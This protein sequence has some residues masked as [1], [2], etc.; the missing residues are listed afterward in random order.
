MRRWLALSLLVAA[1]S[2]YPSPLARAAAPAAAAVIPEG[3]TV[4]E[5]RE[6][7]TSALT[8]Y[9]QGDAESAAKL[10]TRVR[11]VYPELA[12]YAE[13][14]LAKIAETNDPTHAVEHWRVIRERYA[15]S[16]WRGEAELAVARARAAE[17]DWATASRELT[18]ARADLKDAASRAA[19]LG[20]A[21]EAARRLG[22]VRQARTLATE[23][24][25]Q[26]P[27]SA[28]ASSERERAWAER[29][30]VALSVVDSAYEEISLLLG[31]G[32][33]SR[34][35]ELARSAED[36]FRG[37]DKDLPRLLLLEAT[38]LGRSGEEATAQ[39]LLGRIRSRYRRHPAAAQALFRL[40][41]FSWNHD[42]DA[43]ALRSFSAYEREYP[44][45]PQAA[46]ALYAIGRI[47]QEA[48]RYV[49]AANAFARL[50]RR[51]PRAAVADEA[52]FR[53]GWC[54][55]RA[56]QPAAAAR[57]FDALARRASG[58]RAAGLYW[59]ARTRRDDAGF[60]DVLQ[61]FPESYYG[62]LAEMRLGE[63]EASALRG[64][65]SSEPGIPSG[66][67]C[68]GAP[69]S[70]LARFNELKAVHLLPYARVELAAYQG[71]NDG[72]DAFLIV[73]WT[74]VEGYRQ[75]VARA[76]HSEGCGLDSPWVRACYPLAFWR[77]IEDR[78]VERSLDPFLVAGLIRQ[79][80]L[81]DAEARSSA[82]AVGLMQLLPATATRIAPRAGTEVHADR[83]GDPAANVN[84]GTAYLH[85]L[86]DRYQGNLPRALAAYNAGEAAV[87]K[88]SHRYAD[89]ED[90]EFVESIPYRET[91]GYVKRVLQ[92]RRI[93]HALYGTH[94]SAVPSP[95]AGARDGVKAG[96][97]CGDKDTSG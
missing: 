19:A 54:Q 26:Y 14:F 71:E 31:E 25:S 93:Y 7:F 79:E 33:V 72:C 53:V 62:A 35:L 69:S 15:D 27:R 13:R 92:N 43:D 90:D 88:W 29:D 87:D 60:R 21:C 37:D 84:L 16:V 44:L 77:V 17:G 75:A 91:R 2:R 5:R 57:S 30:R 6:L 64:R 78:A 89:L 32:E 20:L 8:L 82:N 76:A 39:T 41:S 11:E 81:F 48:R 55:Y 9:D 67:S 51:Y 1:C 73:S 18:A 46:E 4:D 34:A 58:E 49:E 38:A 3:R 95:S 40:A 68:N 80:S 47:H 28:E 50:A 63:A 83:L 36:R 74:L 59:S 52:S 61:Q 12:D 66:A 96:R 56:G 86:L 24:R 65:V 70:H 45:G 94:P 97:C 23:L 85:E 22:D 42:A 10:F